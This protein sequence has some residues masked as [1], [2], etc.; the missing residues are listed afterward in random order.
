MK[1]KLG[2]EIGGLLMRSKQAQRNPET[3]K[4]PSESSRL[5]FLRIMHNCFPCLYNTINISCSF[6]KVFV[7]QVDDMVAC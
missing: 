4:P 7:V 6:L 3:H 2:I 1:G 5:S